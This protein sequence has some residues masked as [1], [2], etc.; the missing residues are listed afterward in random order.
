MKKL[1]F[2]PIFFLLFSFG[3]S[4]QQEFYKELYEK[5]PDY[6]E[7]DVKQRRFT[8]DLVVDLIAKQE[9]NSYFRINKVGESIEGRSL[10]LLSIG[11]G[12]IDVLLWSQ[13]HGDESTATMALFDIFNFLNSEDFKTEKDVML[14][15]VTLHFLPMLNPDGAE[16]FQRRNALGIDLNR[17]ALRLQ[18][19][20]SKTLKMVRDSLDAD[21]G[22]NLHDQSRYYNAEGTNKPASISYLAPAYNYEK[23]I[24]EVRGN[25]MKLI[26][27]MNNIIQ[28]YAPGQVGRYNDDFE[29][30][31]FGDNIQ[32]WGTSTIL[33]ESGGYPN[34]PEKQEIR[35][36]NFVSILAAIFAIAEEDYKTIAISEYESIPQND[37][38]LYDLKLTEVTYELLGNEY[39]LDLGMN[40]REVPGN[41]PQEYFYRAYV[42]DR[43]DLSTNYAYKS[44]ELSGYKLSSG[45]VYPEILKDL[46]AVEKLDFNKLLEQAY[47]YVQVENLPENE[48]FTDYPVN[49]VTPNFKVAED[50]SH[51]FFLEKDGKPEYAVI[52]G[53]LVKTDEELSAVE[54][55]LILR[56]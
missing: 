40:H 32:K 25:A 27:I 44:K 7:E 43:G 2:L 37:S 20:E 52:N 26:V 8:H 36:L 16:K 30:R 3:L 19:P 42:A 34:D 15:E 33:I 17:D 13:M 21:F 55:A 14:K 1:Q 48:H 18:S 29:P 5:Y 11:S 53:F 35:K 12:K 47:A 45:R 28:N 56:Q 22:F 9:K 50:I 23:S 6:K 38:R 49:L 10:N 41:T 51:S 24:N 54:N 4:A 46:E 39:I 31:A